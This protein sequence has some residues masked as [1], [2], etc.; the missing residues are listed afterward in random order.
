[1]LS[2]SRLK[3]T[4][5][6]LNLK[7]LMSAVPMDE[8]GDYDAS[9]CNS[10]AQV[11][12]QKVL[13]DWT[14]IQQVLLKLVQW[15]TKPKVKHDENYWLHDSAL[16]TGAT[17]I[18]N[19]LASAHWHVKWWHHVE[20]GFPRQLN[21]NTERLTRTKGNTVHLASR[22]VILTLF[23]RFIHPKNPQVEPMHD[24]SHPPLSPLRS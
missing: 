8:S 21:I 17:P 3:D 18:P 9:L 4:Y 23:M 20:P 1:M 24:D 14:W 19:V 22:F 7:M 6:C 11:A 16:C 2:F 5:F 12:Y 15:S 10:R 13:F